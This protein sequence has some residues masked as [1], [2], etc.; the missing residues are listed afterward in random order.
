MTLPLAVLLAATTALRAV[1]RDA[2]CVTLGKVEEKGGKVANS[3]PKLR[4]VA[5]GSSGRRA[6]LRF[7]LQ[8]PTEVVEPLASGAVRQQLGLKLLADDGCN[9]LYVMWRAAPTSELVVTLKRNPGQRT[10]AQCGTRGYQTVRPR[11]SAPP[12]ALVAGKE[13]LLE[14][15]LTAAGLLVTIDGSPV[16]QGPVETGGLSGPAGLRSDNLRFTFSLAVDGESAPAKDHC[17]RLDESD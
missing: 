6:A 7:E 9:L 10:H 4:A 17:T 2:L 1:G 12:P 11:S 15:E 16:W 5:P 3:S 14:A 13:H 8:G